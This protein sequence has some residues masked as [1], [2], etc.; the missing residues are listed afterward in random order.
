MTQFR[1][2]RKA[3]YSLNLTRDKDQSL[4]NASMT[5][6]MNTNQKSMNGLEKWP[7]EKIKVKT[8]TLAS[9][10]MLNQ[11]VATIMILISTP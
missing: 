5:R 10:Y 8:V 7:I 1:C 3:S 11:N 6:D 9:V 2:Q 4:I